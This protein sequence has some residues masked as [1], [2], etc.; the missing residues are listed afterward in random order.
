MANYKALPVDMI[1]PPNF[2]APLNGIW[3]LT[4]PNQTTLWFQLIISDSL[5]ER[6]YISASGAT[7]SLTFRRMDLITSNFGQLN[8]QSRDVIKNATPNVNDRSLF[9]F[10]L[11][12]SDIQN[13]VS[14]GVLFSFTE[15][16][17]NTQWIQQWIIK[18]NL[19]APGH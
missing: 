8:Q 6:R 17:N 3:E 1:N 19:T 15:S 11:T 7:M 14:G 4:S 18:K 9:S 12:Q 10:T 13:I 16:G 5:G 2:Y